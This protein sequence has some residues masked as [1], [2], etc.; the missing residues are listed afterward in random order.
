MAPSCGLLLALCGG[1]CIAPFSGAFTGV[2]LLASRATATATASSSSSPLRMTITESELRVQTIQVFTGKVLEG[3]RKAAATSP[4]YAGMEGFLK[5]Y[6]ESGVQSGVPAAEF[7]RNVEYLMKFVPE[8]MANPF[9][10][11][12]FHSAVRKPIDMYEWGNS[13][14]SVMLEKE[15][16]K[17]V[18]LENLALIKEYL[19]KGENV[20]FL[21]NHQVQGSSEWAGPPVALSS[22]RLSALLLAL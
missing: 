22:N 3:I 6:G 1:L 7:V 18:G 8:V 15:N 9:E 17:V 20:F 16:S 10:F 13:F 21:S 19:D 12:L 11:G 4:V 2:P 5:D 14:V